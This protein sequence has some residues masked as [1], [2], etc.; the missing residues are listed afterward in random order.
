M[1][2]DQGL[3]LNDNE[4][5]FPGK[6]RREQGQTEARRVVRSPRASVALAIEGE[7]FAEKEILSFQCRA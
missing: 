3:W 2:A 1:P 5:I 4:S 6:Q 7:L